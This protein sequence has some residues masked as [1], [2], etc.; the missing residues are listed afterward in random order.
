MKK[1]RTNRPSTEPQTE[2]ER[3]VDEHFVEDVPRKKKKKRIASAPNAAPSAHVSPM[4]AV[5]LNTTH[6]SIR[7]Q[8]PDGQ[9][10]AL[11]APTAD[12]GAELR[13]WPLELLSVDNIRA[14]WGPG[15]FKVQWIAPTPRGG[16]AHNGWG[17]L[18]QV[19][20]LRE[21]PPAP[22]SS[23]RGAELEDLAGLGG[24]AHAFRILDVID[25]R[26]SAQAERERE[27]TRT[28]L[29]FGRGRG[30][31]DRET[32][33]AIR[34]LAGAVRTI[35]QRQELLEQRVVSGTDPG[36][37]EDDDQDADDEDGP[38]AP[39]SDALDAVKAAALNK[40]WSKAPEIVE[41]VLSLIG[42]APSS[43]GA[44]TS[45]GPASSSSPALTPAPTATPA[46]AAPAT[47]APV[48]SSSTGV[49]SNARPIG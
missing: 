6:W 2:P 19:N 7:R 39:G 21:A 22:T 14:T 13:E 25:R 1:A 45:S 31:E 9:L 17:R 26:A 37:D 34:D 20:P 35:A 15:V 16:R 30:D 47:A 36:D 49:P 43:S 32:A 24:L 27:F 11:S 33:R 38:F 23:G 29:E 28:V 41:G 48:S 44:S 5:P 3:D 46:T 12:G 40:L 8:R 10:E 42:G 4:G 18:F